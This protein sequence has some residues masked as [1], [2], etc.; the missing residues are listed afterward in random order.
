MTRTVTRTGACDRGDAEIR[1]AQAI[2]FLE[3][4]ELVAGAAA[5]EKDYSSVAA[6]LAVL[7]GIAASDAASC[8]ALGRRSRSLNHHDAEQLISQIVPG[9]PTAAAN[10]RRLLN[11]KDEAQYGVIHVSGQDLRS[12]LRRAEQLVVFARA[13]L[14]R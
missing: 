6:S 9:G 14:Q 11:L 12:A 1:I 5:A 8:V 3:V 4:A 10:L 13:V 2:K 7:S